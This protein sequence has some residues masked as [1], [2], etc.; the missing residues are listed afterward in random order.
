ME[1]INDDE[2][3]IHLVIIPPNPDYETD[4]EDLDEDDIQTTDIPKDIPGKIEVL[5]LKKNRTGQKS[6]SI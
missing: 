1:N 5:T 4:L 3:N 2:R 6:Q